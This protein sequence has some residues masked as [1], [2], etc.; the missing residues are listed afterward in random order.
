MILSLAEIMQ[1]EQQALKLVKGFFFS[2]FFVVVD[3]GFFNPHCMKPQSSINTTGP[4]YFLEP[5]CSAGFPLAYPLDFSTI[6]DS[7]FSFSL[8]MLGLASHCFELTY[9]LTL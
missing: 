8:R 6:S 1:V 7:F 3:E 2:F 4:Y 5:S 9:F